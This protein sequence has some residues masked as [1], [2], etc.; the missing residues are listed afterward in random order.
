MDLIRQQIAR[1]SEQLSGL[2]ASQK[3]LAVALVAIAAMS[4]WWWSNYA[5][6]R[7]M[8]PILSASMTAEESARVS[9]LLR[10]AGIPFSEQAGRLVV[11][12]DRKFEALS[13]ITMNQ[14]LPGNAASVFDEMLAN[15]NPWDSQSVN[16]ER[17]NHAK[18]QM[19]AR[20]IAGWTDLGVASA[21]VMIS[22]EQKIGVQ[23]SIEP[24]ASVS[25]RT[26]GRGGGDRKLAIAAAEFVSG[27]VAGLR[28]DNVSVVIDGVTHNVRENDMTVGGGSEFLELRRAHERVVEDKIRSVLGYIPG[29][30]VAVTAELN[31]KT[32]SEVKRS[33]DPTAKIQLAT[34]EKTETSSSSSGGTSEEVGAVANIAISAA[35]PTSSNEGSKTSISETEFKTDYG[36]SETTTQAPA[37]D[38]TVAGVSVRVPR[39]YFVGVWK[40]RTANAVSEPSEEQLRPVIDLEISKIREG[41][42]AITQ[43]QSDDL[44]SV[45]EYIQVDPVYAGGEG[46][47]ETSQGA[48]LLALAGSNAKDV[49]VALLA[50]VSLFMVARMVKKST[51]PAPVRPEPVVPTEPVISDNVEP[52][53][54]VVGEGEAMLT[55]REIDPS[56]V[57]ARQM[58]QQVEALVKDDPDLTAALVKR[59]LEER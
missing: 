41:V 27:A 5:A 2:S 4:L 20:V 42:R 35:P 57:E 24:K 26:R 25:I 30:S 16:K 18:A 22:P 52:V 56:D 6:R 39:S 7:D 31:T 43:L 45:A 51:P 23:S 40:H 9:A 1:L 47:S 19:F 46:G 32:V 37:G 55:G 10:G 28:R 13:L 58:S 34:R 8:S 49:A 54:G 36:I 59:W 53:A 29:L 50:V 15:M 14:A 11:P 48:G 12:E 38:A 3:M 21:E 44:I 33:V 17:F